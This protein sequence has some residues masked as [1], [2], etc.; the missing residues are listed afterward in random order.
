MHSNKWRS[1]EC[2]PASPQHATFGR[3]I[4]FELSEDSGMLGFAT[5]CPVHVTPEAKWSDYTMRQL[6]LMSYSS[7]CTLEVIDKNY[8]PLLWKFI[9]IFVP[10]S[11]PVNPLHS[12]VPWQTKGRGSWASWWAQMWRSAVFLR[13]SRS[14]WSGAPSPLSGTWWTSV[15]RRALSTPSWTAE[16]T[17]IETAVR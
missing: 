2:L 8:F 10:T 1:G 6:W 4:F 5:S 16:W 17:W 13:G 9:L 14:R 12:Q 3:G 15:E 7:S 11:L